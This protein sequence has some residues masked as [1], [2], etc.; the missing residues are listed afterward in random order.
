VPVRACQGD[1]QEI[2]V[3]LDSQVRHCLKA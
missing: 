3:P 1:P 2:A